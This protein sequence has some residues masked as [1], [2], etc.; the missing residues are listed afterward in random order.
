MASP[1]AS[2]VSQYFWAFILNINT[3]VQHMCFIF[4]LDLQIHCKKREATGEATGWPLGRPL[5]GHWEAT[6][7]NAASMG[8]PFGSKHDFK[9]FVCIVLLWYIAVNPPGLM[10]ATAGR[11]AGCTQQG[12]PKGYSTTPPALH[13]ARLGSAMPEI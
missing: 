6:V 7:L 8:P 1:V 11:Q 3:Y 12:A 5:G 2:R 10:S 13:L 9:V 4:T